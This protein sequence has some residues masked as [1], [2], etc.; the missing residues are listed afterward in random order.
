[1]GLQNHY[2]IYGYQYIITI[3]HWK[4]A[5]VKS[6]CIHLTNNEASS[7]SQFILII[8]QSQWSRCIRHK[9]TSL[10]R[11]LGSWFRIPLKAWMFGVC[12][13]LFCVYVVL[14]LGRGLATS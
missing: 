11:T 10:A 4:G 14:C 2:K 8:G 3:R 13:G 7:N 1:V 6:S 9:L 5:K 12:M